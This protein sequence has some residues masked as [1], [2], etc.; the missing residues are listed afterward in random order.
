MPLTDEAE[1]L[2][3]SLGDV[4]AR[5]W[6]AVLAEQERL[7]SDPRAWRRQA[8]LSELR[9][10]VGRL[11]DQVDAQAR[12]WVS[13]QYPRAYAAGAAS[14][15]ETLG[16]P[17]EWT[18]VHTDAVTIHA[19]D[20]YDDLLEATRYVRDSTKVLVREVVRSAA[21]MGPVRGQTARATAQ[22]VAR[23]LREK[24][25]IHSVVYANGTKVGL[26][27]YADMAVR[28]KTAVAYNAGTLNHGYVNGVTYYEVFDGPSCGWTSHN[29]T[30]LANGSIRHVNECARFSISHP[31]CIPGGTI[32]RPVGRVLAA[33]RAW[34]SGPLVVVRTARASRLTVTP[35]HPV[36]TD[37]GWVAAHLV[38]EGDKVVTCA[39]E[40][41]GRAAVPSSDFDNIHAAAEQVF[42]LLGPADAGEAVVATP[43][44]FHG[45]GL[46]MKGEVHVVDADRKLTGVRD[47]E[48]VQDAGQGVLQVAVGGAGR[49]HAGGDALAVLS[50][51]ATTSDGSVGGLDGGC[52]VPGPSHFDTPLV[53]AIED[54]A[55]ADASLVGDLRRRLPAE[56]LLDEVVEVGYL[57]SW[58]GHVYDLA[59]EGAAYFADGILVHNCARSFGPRPDVRRKDTAAKAE[60]M[61]GDGQRDRT[62][63]ARE[64]ISAARASAARRQ[65]RTRAR[66]R[67]AQDRREGLVTRRARRRTRE[68]RST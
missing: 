64:E 45:D 49:L 7:L 17:F 44:D 29:D 23:E 25:G 38:K 14:V 9:R 63:Q 51:L 6:N 15:A 31:R 35:N 58:S 30:D 61:P 26:A 8:R 56:V 54:G 57:D 28:T 66:E 41:D 16:S 34:Y 39:G 53:Q 10:E 2:A 60:P 55:V 24:H 47:P 22:A 27:D 5:A 32:V 65:R 12:E 48:F 4:Y 37:R 21:S 40:V 20:L 68:P 1:A 67:R 62:R 46:R 19:R 43:S 11:M 3:K 13:R 18:Q 52:V 42:D 59:S 33:Y 50:G 36:L